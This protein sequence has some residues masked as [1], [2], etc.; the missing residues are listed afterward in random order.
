MANHVD[1]LHVAGPT[2][3]P[4]I[5]VIMGGIAHFGD[6]SLAFRHLFGDF[7]GLL[8]IF[9]LN[10]RQRLAVAGEGKLASIV[11]PPVLEHNAAD[12]LGIK[13]GFDAV[14]NDLRHCRLPLWALAA[15]LKINCL[16]QTMLLSRRLVGRNQSLKIG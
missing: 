13:P 3:A 15:R 6:I 10:Y 12:G 8:P 7:F 9:W 4:I 11:H 14:E 2:W 1:F 16:R 5:G